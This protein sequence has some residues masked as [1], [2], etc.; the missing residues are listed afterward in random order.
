MADPTPTASRVP[1]AA[2]RVV[3]TTGVG[4]M[5][6]TDAQE[7]TRI[8]AGELDRPHLVELP[9]RGPGADVIGRTLGLVVA[10]TGEFAAE[11]TP[12]GWRLAGGRSGAEPG[13]QMRRA[14]AWLA[15]D[16]DRLEEQLDGFTGEV[17]V[18][19]AGPWTLAAGL[20]SPRGTRILADAGA[21]AELA[22][23]LAECAAGH[24]ADMRRR[25]PAA[26]LL[27][28]LDEP[29]LPRVLA[30]RVRTPSGRGALRAPEPAEV[31]ANLQR[32]TAVAG[33]ARVL[34]H[35]CADELPIEVLRRAGVT[36]VSVDLAALGTAAD[37]ALG[38]WWDG[39]GE[40]TLGVAPSVD[41]PPTPRHALAESMARSV[42]GLWQRIGYSIEQV[43]AATLL[44]PTCGL[45][46]ASP[47]WAR[48]VGAEL[49]EATRLLESVG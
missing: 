16:A 22:I 46:A 12:T 6:G 21:C 27:M 13:R 4:S 15:E 7:A 19:L 33:T 42:A 11:T 30:G 39:A 45:A 24:L 49:A 41:P 35:C 26:G 48:A 40:V 1:G 36:G 34:V 44:S 47:A 37:E 18:Q 32:L 2:A 8:V 31:V 5:P 9:A 43:G 25:V 3:R 23:A 38:A 29:S 20:E 17:K 10:T 14:A 28:Q